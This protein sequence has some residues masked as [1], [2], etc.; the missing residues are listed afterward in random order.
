MLNLDYSKISDV[1]LGD[2]SHDPDYW[3]DVYLE[4]ASYDGREMTELELEVVSDDKDFMFK[5]IE[6]DLYGVGV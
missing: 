4:S 6:N 3:C 5:L 1:V 2:L